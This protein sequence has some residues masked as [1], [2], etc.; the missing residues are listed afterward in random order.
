MRKWRLANPEK[1]KRLLRRNLLK[2]YGLTEETCEQL[3]VS[4]GHACDICKRS[5]N[6][7][8][9]GRLGFQVD[10]DH[11]KGHVRGL[12]CVGCNMILGNARDSVELLEGAIEYLKKDLC[13]QIHREPTPGMP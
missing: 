12:L 6:P 11:E 4:Q 8:A 9:K 7:D 2:S 10:H 5:F 13:R 1:W 3:L